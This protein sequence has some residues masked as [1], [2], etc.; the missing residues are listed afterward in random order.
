MTELASTSTQAFI[1]DSIA[2]DVAHDALSFLL[3][4]VQRESDYRN[5]QKQVTA[6]VTHSAMLKLRRLAAWTVLGH[7]GKL[8]ES[9][10]VENNDDD[11][12][13]SKYANLEYMPPDA[14]PQPMIVDSWAKAMVPTR[15]V[16]KDEVPNKS[17]Q[18]FDGGVYSDSPRSASSRVSSRLSSNTGTAKTRK[19]MRST[20][21]GGSRNGGKGGTGIDEEEEED[22]TGRIIEIDDDFE[23]LDFPGGMSLDQLLRQQARNQPVVEENEEEQ[24]DQF[25]LMQNSIEAQIK[26]LPKGKKYVIDKEGNVI[27][28]SHVKASHLPPYQIQSGTKVSDYREP[29]RKG[30][31]SRQRTAGS[32]PSRAGT[33]AS[34]LGVEPPNT[35]GTTQSGAGGK[36]DKRQV[37]V[38]GSR[39]VDSE[40][41]VPS[42]ALK[43]V[44]A[45]GNQIA[46]GAGVALRIDD[47]RKGGPEVPS[48]PGRMSKKEYR[49]RLAKGT[50]DEVATRPGTGADVVLDAFGME[51]SMEYPALQP[52]SGGDTQPMR[53]ELQYKIP[54][55][56]PLAGGRVK[57]RIPL[58]EGGA[59]E[60]SQYMEESDV[61]AA[62]SQDAYDSTEEINTS[63]GLG[64]A[65][66]PEPKDP[67]VELYGHDTTFSGK[68]RDRDLP[69]NMKKPADRRKAAAPP[70]GR[71]S[72]FGEDNGG[73]GAVLSSVAG[74]PT[75][76]STGKE[77]P[78]P[79]SSVNTRNTAGSKNSKLGKSQVGV[80]R[81]KNGTVKNEKPHIAKQIF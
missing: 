45:T 14:D 12:T 39:T 21:F 57:K 49:A 78:S 2:L 7:D 33:A 6:I 17:F 56:D 77:A 53:S 79:Q 54:D 10:K 71:V 9:K 60:G 81:T 25:E 15:V 65:R 46:P 43:D 3:D 23:E 34:S 16:K 52:D 35:A 22:P 28:L 1:D 80:V 42:H 58:V 67:N 70:P 50:A 20:L 40:M 62:D 59:L 5:A 61:L 36:R 72:N 44:L 4:S 13:V 74:S 19:S 68:P 32:S 30:T 47:Q 76:R 18:D 24:I 63:L 55:V 64:V 38:A 26:D 29:V 75:G 37:R 27:P 48:I 8:I 51:S 73:I 11:E 31:G 41:F 69:L 66:L